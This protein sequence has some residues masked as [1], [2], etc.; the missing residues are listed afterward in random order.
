MYHKKRFN[1]LL[2]QQ[3]F[4]KLFLKTLRE[5]LNLLFLFSVMIHH[6]AA[7]DSHVGGD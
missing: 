3:L 1:L 2:V 7:G 6:V 4:D 5:N